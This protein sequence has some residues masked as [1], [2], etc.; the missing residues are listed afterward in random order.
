MY[1]NFSHFSQ[2]QGRNSCSPHLLTFFLSLEFELVC[3]SVFTDD[4]DLMVLPS[5]A[6]QATVPQCLGFPGISQRTVH[7]NWCEREGI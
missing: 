2:I 1:R 6:N 3:A 7:W 5:L 4:L